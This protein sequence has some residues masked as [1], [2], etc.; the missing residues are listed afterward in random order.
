M[1]ILLIDN[2]PKVQETLKSA[3]EEKDYKVFTA[4][5]GQAGLKIAW[6]QSPDMVILD[7]DLPTMNGFEVCRRLR[8]LGVPS[9]LVKSPYNDE[10]SIVKAL[11]MGADDYLQKPVAISV[12]LAKIHTLLRRQNQNPTNSMAV[13]NDGQ[14]SIDLDSRH[15]EMRG[16]PIKLT[17][18]E[19]RLLSILTRKVGS[20]VS[21]EELI[22]EIWGTGKDV[23][24]GSLKLYVHYLRQKI[25]DHPKKP[26]YLLA[27]WG[28]G[29]RLREPK[30]ESAS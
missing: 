3:L 16:R 12:L 25:E 11:E 2:D 24:L 26:R 30:Q 29:Y 23:S 22:R 28:V 7:L 17:P 4:D 5:V 1:K 14:L 6:Q 18:T 13:Y 8:E 9:I 21:H 15:V 27:E 19:F 10:R 20:V